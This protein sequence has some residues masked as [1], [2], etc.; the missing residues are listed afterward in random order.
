LP[1]LSTTINVPAGSVIL[2]TTEGAVQTTSTAATGF[3]I[4]DIALAI[5]NSIPQDGGYQ[6]VI[7]AN[8]PGLNQ[9]FESWKISLVVSVPAGMHTF[10]VAALGNAVP[11]GSADATVGGASGDTRQGSLSAVV[12]KQ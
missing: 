5:D 9:I 8:S 11:A 10:A 2:L 6:R 4:V 3:S 7:V 1:G 12:I